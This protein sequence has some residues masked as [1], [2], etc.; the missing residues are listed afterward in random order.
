MRA[1]RI[2]ADPG[3]NQ[4]TAND[5]GN[6]VDQRVLYPAIGNVHDVVTVGLEQ[7]AFGRPQ[8]STNGQARAVPESRKIAR[9]HRHISQAMLPRQLL[10][11]SAGIARDAFGAKARAAVARWPMRTVARG[12]SHPLTPAA[13]PGYAPHRCRRW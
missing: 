8:S 10:Q 3:I 9:M 11:L 4:G 2:A 13:D 7:T 1:V 12:A 6:C 5:G